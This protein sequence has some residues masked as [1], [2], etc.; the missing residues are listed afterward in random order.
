M[1]TKWITY[2]LVV[3]ALAHS[4]LWSPMAISIMNFFFS[5]LKQ[6]GWCNSNVTAT[7]VIS[8]LICFF[9][10]LLRLI[11]LKCAI[12]IVWRRARASAIARF[13]RCALRSITFCFISLSSNLSCCCF[14]GFFLCYRSNLCASASV[15]RDHH[16]EQLARISNVFSDYMV[17]QHH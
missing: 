1:K 10:L 8:F 3:F 16:I 9:F 14:S 2:G 15:G 7:T 12:S 4:R 11:R 6:D 13:N 5:L 17:A